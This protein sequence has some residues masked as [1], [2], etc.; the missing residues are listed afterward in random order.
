MGIS[1]CNGCARVTCRRAPAPVVA[2]VSSRFNIGKLSCGIDM[3]KAWPWLWCVAF[4]SVA[5]SAEPAHYIDLTREFV[6]FADETTDLEDAARVAKFRTRMD[7]LLPGFY[8]PR[9]G[10]TDEKYD[11]R[12]ARALKN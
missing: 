2:R 1:A 10:A 7:A 11:A 4:L 3:S 6:R 12:V 9:F 8:T 5:A